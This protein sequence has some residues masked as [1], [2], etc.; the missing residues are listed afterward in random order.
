MSFL[1]S[2]VEET[3]LKLDPILF[4]EELR[5]EWQTVEV[6]PVTDIPD[7]YVL[8][9]VVTVAE[10]VEGMLSQNLDTLSL[11]GSLE[12]CAAMAVWYRKL[13]SAQ[14]ELLFYEQGFN[15]HIELRGETT[16]QDIIDACS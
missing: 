8:R 1:I 14:Y 2:P 15:C 9:W 16:A 11:D 10:R 13:V 12:D 6:Q 4:A 3:D 5:N 7:I